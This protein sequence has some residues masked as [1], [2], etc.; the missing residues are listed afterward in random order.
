MLFLTS[1]Y[2]FGF[3]SPLRLLILLVV[4]LLLVFV[5]LVRRRRA[6]YTVQ[7]TNVG[8][9]A[10]VLAARRRGFPGWLGLGILALAL[11]TT[12][13]ALAHPRV[14]LDGRQSDPPRSSCWSTCRTRCGLSTSSPAG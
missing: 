14:Q 13:A 6:R 9:L 5:A 1:P 3:G 2:H 4:P 10:D 11:A 8:L 7:F 12:S